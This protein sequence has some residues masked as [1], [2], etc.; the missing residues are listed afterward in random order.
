MLS[1]LQ[2]TRAKNSNQ[3][4]VL[5]ILTQIESFLNKER[6]SIDINLNKDIDGNLQQI[7]KKSLSIAKLVKEKHEEELGFHG[8]LLLCSEKISDGYLSNRVNVK[9]DDTRLK[10]VSRSFNKMTNKMQNDFHTMIEILKEYEKG[11]FLRSL[12]VKAYRGGEIKELISGINALKNALTTMLQDND[13]DG[14]KLMDQA[15]KLAHNMQLV[16]T[17]FNI[18][19]KVINDISERTLDISQKAQK[20]NSDLESM[21][22]LSDKLQKSATVGQQLSQGTVSSM[23][24]IDASIEN[25]TSAI[26]VIDQIAFQTNILSLN[27]A[28][29]AATAGEAGKGFAVVA[30]EVRNL[31]IRSAE[32]AKEIKELVCRANEKTNDG[33]DISKEMIDGYMSLKNDLEK[34]DKLMDNILI[35]SKQQIETITAL[36]TTVVS[37]RKKTDKFINIANITDDI[38]NEINKISLKIVDTNS[39][40]DFEGKSH[41]DFN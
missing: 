9:I 29:E 32:A 16:S 27:A 28:V 17:E 20:N 25:I 10:Y 12:D 23:K 39:S 6:N 2:N 38:S 8:E 36:D 14:H 11:H 18:Q 41:R 22:D 3:E 33:K 13:L 5:D 19:H 1:F 21:K 37:L 30:A 31:A 15:Q 26:E 4:Y 34:S 40:K 35:S 7:Y 24:G